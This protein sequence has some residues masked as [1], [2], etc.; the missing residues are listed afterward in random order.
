MAPLL[1][2]I[3]VNWNTR[4]L[5]AACLETVAADIARLGA[6]PDA[7]L[8]Q[9]IV[10]DNASTDGSVAHIRS[11]YPWVQL[12][13]NQENV[14]FAVANNGALAHCTGAYVLLLNSDTEVQPGALDTLLRFMDEH[15]E[16][17]IVGARYLNPDGT[18]Q[19]SCYPAPT[20][21]RESWRMFHLDRL[22][23]YGIYRMRDWPLDQPR[24][25][26]T[27]QG[28]ALLIR[29]TITDQLGLFD[30]DYF[31]YTE[32]IDLC[33][34]VRQAGWQIYWAPTATIIHYGGQSTRQVAR[35][36]FL[37]LYQSKVLYFRKHH[38]RN[39]TV[40][41]KAVLLLATA[42]RLT[43]TPLAWLQGPERRTQSLTLAHHYLALAQN[44]P[45]M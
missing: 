24:A 36:M 16:A 12:L 14:G 31:M 41:Y 18:L 45:G 39:A 5:T 26:D 32:E 6:T 9:T 34:R 11:A 28:A 4:D 2:I 1:S 40:L 21:L 15:P 20:L 44:L 42:L 43:L 35:T 37:H 19:S 10:V 7:P 8:V 13:E 22:Y 27:V 3:I 38:G 25:V 23:P 17:G 30:T 33:R 29:R